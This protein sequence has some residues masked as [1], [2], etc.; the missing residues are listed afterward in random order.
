VHHVFFDSPVTDKSFCKKPLNMISLS[1]EVM[2]TQNNLVILSHPVPF[3]YIFLHFALAFPISFMQFS[4]SPETDESFWKKPH[5]IISFINEVMSTQKKVDHF[6]S[7]CPLPKHFSP[8]FACVFP[9]NHSTFDNSETDKS[10][11]RKPLHIISF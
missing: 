1:N 11:C 7:C 2:S 6:I 9:V 3:Q 4:D 5:H 8:L 10:F